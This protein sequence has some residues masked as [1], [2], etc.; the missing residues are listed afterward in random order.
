MKTFL[1]LLLMAY[2]PVIAQTDSIE[3][4]NH[5]YYKGNPMEKVKVKLSVK[6]RGL[7]YGGADSYL[8]IS[9]T[10]SKLN[11][12]DSD[13]VY[14]YVKM[15]GNL[16]GNLSLYKSEVT[17]NSRR[18][19]YYQQRTFSGAS[20]GGEPISY[21]ISPQDDGVYKIIPAHK[22]ED[23]E[24]IFIIQ[25]FSNGIGEAFP[26]SVGIEKPV[27]RDEFDKNR[28]K[29]KVLVDDVYGG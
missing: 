29:R 20:V 5:P 27:E 26:F 23:G 13:S 28:K 12:R 3:F 24:Y 19:K 7:G 8:E 15:D 2:I 10:K 9:G 11:I 16:I 1:L 18:V 4:I 14:F 6:V 22:L 25:G 21:N 17:K